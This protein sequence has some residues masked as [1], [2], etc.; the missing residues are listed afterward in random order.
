M[1]SAKVI[2]WNNYERL[3]SNSFNRNFIS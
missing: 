2:V 3:I 1:G